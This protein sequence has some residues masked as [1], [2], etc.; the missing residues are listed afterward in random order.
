MGLGVFIA[1]TPLART[2]AKLQFGIRNRGGCVPIRWRR[3]A[4]EA[5]APET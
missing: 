3:E 2:G 4:L 5:D 1:L